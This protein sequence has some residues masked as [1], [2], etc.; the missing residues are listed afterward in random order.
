[1]TTP[2]KISFDCLPLRSL[3][4]LDS[5]PDATPE[6]EAL[7]LKLRHAIEKHGFYN[8]YYLG[9]GLCEFNLTNDPAVGYLAFRFEGAVLTDEPDERTRVADLEVVLDR[10]SCDWL[11]AEVVTWFQETVM[12]AVR[13]EFDRFIASGDLEKTRQRLARMSAEMIAGGGFVGL[14][15]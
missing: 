13:I 1:M 5:P 15:L 9:N 3:P 4:R 12:Q 11:N 2:V 14:G 7:F 6:Q 8:S 10:E